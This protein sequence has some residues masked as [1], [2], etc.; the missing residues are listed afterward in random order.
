MNNGDF[1]LLKKGRLY[2]PMTFNKF[3]EFFTY[4]IYEFIQKIY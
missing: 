4:Y 3:G 2:I 1:F